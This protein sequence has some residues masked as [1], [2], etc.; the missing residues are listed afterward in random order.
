MVEGRAGVVEAGW[1]N[2]V[3]IILKKCVDKSDFIKI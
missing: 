2:R 3:T 1:V